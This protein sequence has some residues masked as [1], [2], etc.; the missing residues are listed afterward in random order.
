MADWAD[1]YMQSPGWAHAQRQNAYN[2]QRNPWG[3]PQGGSG[4]G[5]GSLG[6]QQP[7]S[8][9]VQ[10]P[11]FY[12]QG[13]GGSPAGYGMTPA[14]M[15]MGSALQYAF[16][17]GFQNAMNGAMQQMMLQ[18]MLNQNASINTRQIEAPIQA[19]QIR[20]DA[21]RDISAN[22]TSAISPLLQALVGGLGQTAFGN[23]AGGFQAAGPDGKVFASATQG[24]SLAQ[25]TQ[26][27][28]Y[29]PPTRFPRAGQTKLGGF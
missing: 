12:G 18:N 15:G 26:T 5:W 23:S 25:P 6:Q 21:A 9:A 4:N 7:A 17:G 27:Q 3:G 28:Q 13:G 10:I 24:G 22:R 19:E 2:Y 14:D 1:E 8:S 16:G 11:M 29:K 20:A